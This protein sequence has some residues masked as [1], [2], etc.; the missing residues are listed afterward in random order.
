MSASVR[1]PECSASTVDGVACAEQFGAVLAWE[2]D[3]A[4]LLA[5]HFLTVASY[6]LQHPSRFTAD[7]LDRLRES[8]ALYLE[9]ELAVKDIR[10]RMATV[11]DG[12]RRVMVREHERV[13]VARAWPLTIA[14][15]YCGGRAQGAA[16]RVRAWAASVREALA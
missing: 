5:E 7:A 4:E 11:F 6:N 15:V 9:G 3:D 10:R 16:E 12:P 1:C 2:Q 13:V 14:D 8:L